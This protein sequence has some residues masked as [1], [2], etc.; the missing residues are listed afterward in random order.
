MTHLSNKVV[1]HLRSVADVPDLC[2]TKYQI[3]ETLGRGGMG[4][5]YLGMD[6]E[7]QRPVAIKV[8]GIAN[9]STD[10]RKR[11]SREARVLAQLEHPGIVPVHDVGQLP[12]GRPFYA[13]KLVRGEGLDRY[14]ERPLTI[15]ALLQLFE[16]ICETVA[17]AHAQGVIHRD[18]KPE[19]IM[20]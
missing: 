6:L 9:D 12:D 16:R 4:T 10:L 14:L 7:L 18:L 17:F 20:V 15:S 2:D 13:M 11:L 8:V 5:V 19:N 3:L 1:D